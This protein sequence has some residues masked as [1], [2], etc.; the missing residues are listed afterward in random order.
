MVINVVVPVFLVILVGAI[1]VQ[2]S[3]YKNQ[4]LFIACVFALTLAV[5]FIINEFHFALVVDTICL[6]ILL[7]WLVL[8]KVFS[9]YFWYNGSQFQSNIFYKKRVMVLVPH[10]D[11][12]LNLASDILERYLQNESEVFIVY[13]TNG[14]YNNFG[15]IRMMEALAVCKEIG[16]D[17]EHVIFLGY[18]DQWQPY[19]ES[20]GEKIRHIYHANGIVQMTSQAGYQSTYALETKAPFSDGVKY[21]RDNFFGDIKKV[22]MT[23]RPDVLYVVDF[24]SHPDHRAVS[25]LF[26]EAMGSIFK[27][28]V[29]FRPKVFKG[30]CYPTAYYASD[31]F[32]EEWNLKSTVSLSEHGYMEENHTFFWADR[33]R[34]PV[35]IENVSRSLSKCKTYRLLSKYTTQPAL[36]KAGRIINGDKVFWERNTGSIIYD[37][38][39]LDGH[40]NITYLND[41]KLQEC[42]DIMKKNVTEYDRFYAPLKEDLSNGKAFLKVM[43]PE[44]RKISSVWIYGFLKHSTSRIRLALKTENEKRYWVDLFPGIKFPVKITF[45]QEELSEFTIEF[46]EWSEDA[47]G[48]LEIEAYEQEKISELEFVK[49]MDS[50]ENF[51]YEDFFAE[52]KKKYEIYTYPRLDGKRIWQDIE[53]SLESKRGDCSYTFEDDC[54]CVLCPKGARGRLTVKKR[55]NDV[56]SDTICFSHMSKL[57]NRIVRYIVR[58]SAADIYLYYK[59]LLSIFTHH[60]K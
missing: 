43:L 46:E 51:I 52:D 59:T 34:I 55:G 10:Q 3:H 8:Q 42:N 6:L 35:V 23:I 26:E 38:E 45:E 7:M 5:T 41:F 44:K 58:H 4:F 30:F 50:K 15:T 24:D 2:F 18:G 57:K 29:L 21:T 56:I 49:I 16:I 40:G 53:V 14:D 13:A 36:G 22:I 19:T 1:C 32:L 37:A 20:N 48:L 25:L 39:I 28:D 54:I 31:D 33:I 11:D 12:E 9:A 27:D 60:L 17:Q 47:G